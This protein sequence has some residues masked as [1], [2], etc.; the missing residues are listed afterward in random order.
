MTADAARAEALA[1]RL[2]EFMGDPFLLLADLTLPLVSYF[3]GEKLNELL[4]ELFGE[5]QVE[6]TWLPFYCI[7]TNVR[8]RFP[9]RPGAA[10]LTAPSLPPPP[11]SPAP[12]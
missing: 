12:Q 7:S 4:R 10:R 2:G 5:V 3:S 8:R 6:D 1:R 11:R 9:R